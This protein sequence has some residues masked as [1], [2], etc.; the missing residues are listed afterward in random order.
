MYIAK[1][2]ENGRIVIPKDIVENCVFL[3]DDA[4]YGKKKLVFFINNQG[5]IGVSII[6]KFVSFPDDFKFLGN[7]DYDSASHTITIPENVDVAL[8]D[9][10]DYYFATTLEGRA[11][12][13]IYK[14]QTDMQKL[15]AILSNVEKT[16]EGFEAYFDEDV[17]D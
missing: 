16:L 1:K 7:C 5:E 10:E 6:L 12:F 2:D 15:S 9:G 3:S 14:R 4:I 13:Y 17:D 8:G 11:Y